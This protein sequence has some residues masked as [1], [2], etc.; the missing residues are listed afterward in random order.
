MGNK[1]DAF[2]EVL[3]NSGPITL[4]RTSNFF[5]HSS[6]SLQS[7]SHTPRG[8]ILMAVLGE[9]GKPLNKLDYS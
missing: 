2:K 9:R 3:Y 8:F 6:A 5:Y 4:C 7:M 1:A